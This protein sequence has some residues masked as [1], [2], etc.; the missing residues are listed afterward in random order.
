MSIDHIIFVDREGKCY[1][2]INPIP[3]GW[4]EWEQRA[5][6]YIQYAGME[7]LYIYEE[8]TMPVA[9]FEKWR[10]WPCE[11]IRLSLN[12]SLQPGGRLEWCV[13]EAGYDHPLPIGVE[14]EFDFVPCAA[15]PV[16]DAD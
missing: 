15:F 10:C 14:Y 13:A 11:D 8:P 3:E 2:D 6:V 4:R 1:K 5:T 7:K 16:E 9:D 12:G